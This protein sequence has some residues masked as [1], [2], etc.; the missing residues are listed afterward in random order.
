MSEGEKEPFFTFIVPL[1]LCLLR[2]GI[3]TPQMK[4]DSFKSCPRSQRVVHQ[5]LFAAAVLV[6]F[7]FEVFAAMLSYA[8]GDEFVAWVVA[9]GFYGL[10]LYLI[11]LS[12][13]AIRVT[14]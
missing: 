5:V 7:F 1:G 10:Y 9:G 13:R 12:N 3:G 4:L 2:A 8:R 6:L 14:E 11:V